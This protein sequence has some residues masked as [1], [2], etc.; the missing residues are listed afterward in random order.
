MYI[1]ILY[2]RLVRRNSISITNH[3]LRFS[4]CVLFIMLFNEVNLDHLQP[5]DTC[6]PFPEDFEP[7]YQPPSRREKQNH[8]Y[9]I[10]KLLVEI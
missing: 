8:L 7:V 3:H 1:N 4:K 6:H 10:Y 5:D 9:I 2:Y